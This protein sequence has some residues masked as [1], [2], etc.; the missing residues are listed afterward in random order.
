MPARIEVRYAAA[1]DVI[2][3]TIKGRSIE[4][5]ARTNFGEKSVVVKNDNE[6][7]R[8]IWADNETAYGHITNAR[9]EM[10]AE[11]ITASEWAPRPE[12]KSRQ[13]RWDEAVAKMQDAISA[14]EDIW[15]EKEEVEEGSEDEFDEDDAGG[16]LDD[17][18][19]SFNEGVGEIEELKEEYADWRSNLPDGLQDSP[20]AEKLDEV[21][22]LEVNE[23]EW[24]LDDHDSSE[25]E[26][27]VSE[28]EAAELPL[29]W[30]RD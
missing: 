2:R 17:A 27:M 30:G 4:S 11:I 16:R 25:A 29:G 19:T 13:A 1:G 10:V 20:V 6:D 24:E 23:V 8:S 21:E 26:N 7:G 12:P 14:A 3:K 18:S 22:G 15:L 5:I 9:G 28:L